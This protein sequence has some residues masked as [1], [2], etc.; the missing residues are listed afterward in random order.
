MYKL[1]RSYRGSWVAVFMVSALAVFCTGKILSLSSSCDYSHGCIGLEALKRSESDPWIYVALF[2]FGL[3]CS[4][5]LSV[6]K[7]KLFAL[8][9][10][11]SFIFFFGAMFA[12]NYGNP[13]PANWKNLDY[14]SG[15]LAFHMLGSLSLLLI[16]I[17][18]VCIYF[19]KKAEAK[20]ERENDD[21][22]E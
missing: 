15:V 19:G 10:L 9:L 4:F 7:R 2:I 12:G 21:P 14:W 1:L 5:G 8:S 18:K 6:G 17:L 20:I 13:R 22:H 3:L 11:L 16:W